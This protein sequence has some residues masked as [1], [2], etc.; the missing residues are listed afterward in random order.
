MQ[1][2]GVH[3]KA[4]SWMARRVVCPSAT[5]LH[6]LHMLRS[7][8]HLSSNF[9]CSLRTS[10]TSFRNSSDRWRI[11]VAVPYMGTGVISATG[12]Y[13]VQGGPPAYYILVSLNPS[14]PQT[15]QHGLR[16]SCQ[17]AAGRAARGQGAPGTPG[18]EAILLV[19]S[20]LLLNASGVTNF[21]FHGSGFRIQG[22]GLRM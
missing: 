16:C 7:L 15:P 2:L 19:F 13:S 6:F 18:A 9:T 5:T 21:P 20:G 1:T 12:T 4:W 11:M 14:Q 17:A 22:L 8:G 10:A 3:L